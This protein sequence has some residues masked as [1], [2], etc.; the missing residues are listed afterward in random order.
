MVCRIPNDVLNRALQQLSVP[1]YEAQ[2]AHGEPH[3][4]IALSQLK[5]SAANNL[6][7]QFTKVDPR[8]LHWRRRRVP[9]PFGEQLNGTQTADG[10][11]QPI[12]IRK[13]R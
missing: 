9:G 6:R 8:H 13:E 1:M 2:P 4:I 12:D 3:R 7:Y 5:L 10:R 11:R